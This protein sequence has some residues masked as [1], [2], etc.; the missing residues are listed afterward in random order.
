MDKIVIIYYDV[1]PS[2]KSVQ[3]FCIKVFL[4]NIVYF[5]SIYL[6]VN[7]KIYTFQILLDEIIK[8]MNIKGLFISPCL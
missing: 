1:L 2:F 6:Y 7:I 5:L 8:V 3:F 4:I